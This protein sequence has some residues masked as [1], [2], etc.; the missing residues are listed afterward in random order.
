MLRVPASRRGPGAGHRD[1]QGRRSHRTAAAGAEFA[2]ERALLQAYRWT[3]APPAYDAPDCA[4][5]SRWSDWPRSG[6]TADRDD[7]QGE[8]RRTDHPRPAGRRRRVP[9]RR[10]ADHARE[11]SGDRCPRVWRDTPSKPCSPTLAAST[12]ARSRTRSMSPWHLSTLPAVAPATPLSGAVTVGAVPGRLSSPPPSGVQPD[13]APGRAAVRGGGGPAADA[14]DATDDHRDSPPPARGLVL[15]G[16]PHV[17]TYALAA[18]RRLEL[19]SEAGARIGTTLDVRRTAQE[20]AEIA[21]PRWPTSSP[22]TCPRP[23]CAARSPPTPARPAPHG[24]PRHPRRLPL[25]SGRQAGRPPARPH[26]S[27]G[28]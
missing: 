17:G 25:L 4:T 5:A 9:A 15:V 20:L 27:C 3:P 1:P 19:L 18:R 12:P 8:G 7:P 10:S 21:V 24:G 2:R 13:A 6:R 28:A 23:Y 22:S 26:P 16:E 14:V 11:P